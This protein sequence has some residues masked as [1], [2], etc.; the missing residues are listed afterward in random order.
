[1]LATDASSLTGVAD[2]GARK[3]ST[4][5]IDLRG[6]TVDRSD[7]FVPSDV[8]PVLREHGAA[9]RIDLA[10]KDNATN[11]GALEATL[12]TADAGEEGADPHCH[13]SGNRRA[14][15]RAG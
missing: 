15:S 14:T 10:L 7:I 12:E 13:T 9:E 5:Q 8:G 4:E 3:S 2:I 6:A 1:V 11:P